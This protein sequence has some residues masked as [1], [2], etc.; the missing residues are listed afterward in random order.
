MAYAH[1]VKKNKMRAEKAT[2]DYF[3]RCRKG[4][5]LAVDAFLTRIPHVC[6][7]TGAK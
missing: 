1:F 7:L 6:E 4:N 5:L 3:F 2:S